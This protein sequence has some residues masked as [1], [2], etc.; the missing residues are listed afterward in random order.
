MGLRV[1]GFRLRV[2][3]SGFRVSGLGFRVLSQTPGP[4]SPTPAAYHLPSQ[5]DQPAFLGSLD[6]YRSPSHPG[7]LS[8][9]ARVPSTGRVG[10][11]PSR[12]RAL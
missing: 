4:P 2:Q 10:R 9:G 7:G 1:E 6:F 5:A 11:L 3:G 12:V 8:A